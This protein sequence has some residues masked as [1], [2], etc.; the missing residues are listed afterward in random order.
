MEVPKVIDFSIKVRENRK[1][2]KR[3]RI[4]SQNIGIKIF[5]NLFFKKNYNK[6][7]DK[8]I[9]N[10]RIW[11]SRSKRLFDFVIAFIAIGFFSPF[12]LFI[13]ILIR[14]DSKG[15]MLYKGERVGQRS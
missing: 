3:I 13:G 1:N 6:M 5:E 10:N 15:P 9:K 14:L 12:V 7:N 11:Y 8:E 2:T 4:L